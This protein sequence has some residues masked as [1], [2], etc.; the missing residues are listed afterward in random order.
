MTTNI[1]FDEGSQRSFI[2]EELAENLNLKYTETFGGKDMVQ[3]LKTSTLYLIADSEE[4]NQIH[5]VVVQCIATK[6]HTY[7]VPIKNLPYLKHLKFAHSYDGSPFD[8]SLLIG[9]YHYWDIVGNDI[10]R[11][12]GPVAESS[13][14][15]YLL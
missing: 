14:I 11:G 3:T 4:T 15:G 9:V 5:V 1:L 13:K 8:I 2:T 6:V 7:H 10:I 12:P